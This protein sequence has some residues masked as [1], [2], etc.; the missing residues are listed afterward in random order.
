MAAA[1]Q[2]AAAPR[3]R[4]ATV[5][6]LVAAAALALVAGYQALV[7]IP[8]LRDR[9]SPRAVRTVALAPASRGD[10]AVIPAA[11]ARE[12]VTLMVDVNG[13]ADNGA[14]GFDLAGPGNKSR[15][16]G[17]ADAPAPGLP[18]VIWLPP[19]YLTSGEYQLTIQT[20]TPPA[21]NVGQYRFVVR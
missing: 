19:D 7:T 1:S 2:P 3:W 9:G 18:L 12:G 20:S 4:P 10:A 13:V 15:L 14:L 11:T 21:R 16:S 8:G 6:P 17:T 5:L